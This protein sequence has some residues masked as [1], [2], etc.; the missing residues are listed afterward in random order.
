VSRIY[1]NLLYETWEVLKQEEFSRKPFIAHIF[2]FNLGSQ[3]P[4]KPDDLTYFC[5]KIITYNNHMKSQNL[6]MRALPCYQS[7]VFNQKIPGGVVSYLLFEKPISGY[8]LEEICV[9]HC[10]KD[11]IC[12]YMLKDFTN[13]WLGSVLYSQYSNDKLDVNFLITQKG[14]FF[15]KLPKVIKSKSTQVSMRNLMSKK[16]DNDDNEEDH[17]KHFVILAYPRAFSPEGL[18]E[19]DKKIDPKLKEIKN[20]QLMTHIGKLLINMYKGLDNSTNVPPPNPDDNFNPSGLNFLNYTDVYLNL[21]TEKDGNFS[22]FRTDEYFGVKSSYV[23]AVHAFL[24][25]TLTTSKGFTDMDAMLKDSFYEF[26][27]K[28]V[29]FDPT[30]KKQFDTIETMSKHSFLKSLLDI[31]KLRSDTSFDK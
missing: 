19:K 29:M 3:F 14:L 15:G 6:N 7:N 18:V 8:K 25:H 27:F 2:K 13:G 11:R 21:N 10:A 30:S 28:S 9:P 23:N 20:K 16:T 24:D 1:S 26:I 5:Q 12:K 22:Q 17:I 4:L 31:N